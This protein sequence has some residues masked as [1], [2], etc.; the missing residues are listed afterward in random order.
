[1][2]ATIISTL[3]L[4][5]A[6]YPVGPLQQGRNSIE[7][8]ITTSDNR[9]LENVRVFL[10][11]DGY[12]QL[13]LIYTDGSG[14]YQFKSLTADNYYVQ[15]EPVGTGYERQMQRVE[16]NPFSMGRR[17]GAEIFRVDFV[18]KPEKPRN[19]A[20]RIENVKSR[21]LVFYQVVPG[22]A[23]DAYQS[24]LQSLS[25][26]DLKTAEVDLTRAIEIFP[27]YY[28][29]LDTLG[30]EYVKHAVYDAAVPL[31]AH[32]I[33]VNKNGW[34]SLYALGIALIE[35]N[36]RAEGVQALRDAVAINPASINAAMRL[37]LEL[38]KD[39]QSHDEAVK[40][41]AAV[42]QMAGKRLPEAYLILASLYSK[43]NQNREAAD[44]LESYL[45]SV[46]ESDQRESIRRKIEEL[47]QKSQK[48]SGK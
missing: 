47:R 7:G 8:R 36:R 17:S 9:S 14:R 20:A 40:M 31:L 27:D 41:L 1:L 22:P 10:L 44:A 11:S 26:S 15:V 25:R 13:K 3:L 18:L 38:A 5:L 33:E 37:G 39:S 4:F 46:R 29:A 30:S 12:S 43:N 2:L 35:L 6:T 34:H 23:K 32:A 28:E 24:A 21:G 16:V 19:N 48:S 45:H 42:T